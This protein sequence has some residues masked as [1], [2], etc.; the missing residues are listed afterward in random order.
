MQNLIQLVAA[1][2][3]LDPKEVGEDTSPDTTDRWDS[4]TS[5]RLMMALQEA[6][7]VEFSNAE[8]MAMRSVGLIRRSTA[9]E[10][11]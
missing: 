11:G 8:I 10:K 1:V 5:V 2:L 6:Y 3:E 4:L 9:Q 7:G